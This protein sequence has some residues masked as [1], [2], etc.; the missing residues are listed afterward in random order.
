M[1]FS[2]MMDFAEQM[3]AARAHAGEAVNDVFLELW[4][5]RR[6]L[7][8]ETSLKTKLFG[9]LTLR[10]RKAEEKRR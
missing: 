2:Q 4:N 5:G 10:L 1:Y 6:M 8:A 7:Q 3:G 9:A